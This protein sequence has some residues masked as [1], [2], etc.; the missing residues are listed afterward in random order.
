VT[1]S[2][3]VLQPAWY[4]RFE[5][6]RQSEFDNVRDASV[7]ILSIDGRKWYVKSQKIP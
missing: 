7:V 5:A 2:V 6:Q 1:L 3:L 4:L